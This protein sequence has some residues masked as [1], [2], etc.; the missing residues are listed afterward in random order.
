MAL[1][2][3]VISCPFSVSALK[4]TRLLSIWTASWKMFSFRISQ[5]RTWFLVC[6]LFGKTF[7]ANSGL[8]KRK[9]V[10]KL[11]TSQPER[12]LSCLHMQ[13]LLY[14]II[15]EA[16]SK[17]NPLQLLM[18]KHTSTCKWHIRHKNL[19]FFFTIMYTPKKSYPSGDPGCKGEE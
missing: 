17:I 1:K 7:W 14:L 5:T 9:Y 15:M 13:M 8:T 11:M 10:S 18:V 12:F 2:H 6:D 19:I 3:T 4:G 16:H